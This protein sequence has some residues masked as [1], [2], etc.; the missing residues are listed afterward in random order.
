MRTR[1]IPSALLDIHAQWI[2]AGRPSQ[3]GAAWARAPWLATF[4]DQADY[5]NVI[6]SPLDRRAVTA[7]CADAASDT[8]SAAR[9]FI[10]A[11]IWGYGRVDY[12]P[13]R[14]ARILRGMD[15]SATILQ[16]AAR[17]A[18]SHGGPAAF[19]WLSEHRLRGLGVSFATKYLFFC[20]DGRSVEPA[21][22][23]DRLVTAWLSHHADW[24]LSLDWRRDH[25]R[26][27]VQTITK[28]AS[29]L[30][31]SPADAEYLIFATEA[32]ADPTSQWAEPAFIP[33]GTTRPTAGH[34]PAPEQLAVLEALD[35]AAEAFAAMPNNPE[36]DI[37]DFEYGLRQLRRIVLGRPRNLDG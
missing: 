28:W 30:Q 36:S 26:S 2:T 33:D 25:Y 7:L 32:T 34:E 21:L 9:G 37:D 19:D 10:A 1:P 14:T 11:M 4:P 29:D 3:R 22:V 24:A 8:A 35:D 6:P 5:L 23:L 15:Q 18:I 16:A 31:I 12:G 17:E 20:T 27:Y 13:F